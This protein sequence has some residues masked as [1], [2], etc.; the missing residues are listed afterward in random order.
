MLGRAK[1]AAL[2]GEM[3]EAAGLYGAAKYVRDATGAALPP[4]ER[5]EQ[6]RLIAQARTALGEAEFAHAFEEGRRKI[7]AEL[8]GQL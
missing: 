6:E 8:S 7:R 2:Q 3:P 4:Q 1:I 5:A